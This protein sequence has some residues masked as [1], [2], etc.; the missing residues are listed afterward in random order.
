MP[1]TSEPKPLPTPLNYVPAGSVP[2]RVSADDSFYSLADRPDVKSFGLSPN[3]LC[4]FNFG[5]RKPPEINWYLYHKVG[6]RSVTHD[7]YNYKFSS[8]DRPGVVYLPAK[9]TVIPPPQPEVRLNSWFG[10]GAKAGT[11]FVVV[12]IETIVGWV[13]SLDEMGKGMTLTCSVNRLGPG[14]GA[15]LGLCFI[16]VSGVKAPQQLN[17]WQQ[18]DWDFNLSL[19]ENWGKI[20][21]S[22]GK[23]RKFKPLIDAVSKIGARTPKALK[24]ALKA[25]PDRWVDL[26]KNARSMKDSL[27][28]DPNG[29]PNVFM[30]DVPFISGGAEVSLFYGLQNFN[31]VYDN[32]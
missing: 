26:I 21:Q 32:L 23:V 9:P 5:T 8:S 20:G 24:A 18:M 16:Y 17:G 25:E 27:G 28:I 15:G 7:G 30:F 4:Y 2:Y 1:I 6:C 12:G 22:A 11:Q 31:A 29:D 14:V 19:G 13:F 3:D 10:L